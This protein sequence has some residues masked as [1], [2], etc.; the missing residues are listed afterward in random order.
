MMEYEEQ[1]MKIASEKR[2]HG[3]T[4]SDEHMKK[5]FARKERESDMHDGPL[6][7][8]RRIRMGR[9]NYPSACSLDS[10]E[11]K[12]YQVIYSIEFMFDYAVASRLSSVLQR[13]VFVSLKVFKD[14]TMS[15]KDST[16][17]PR[18]QP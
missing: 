14:V 15:A 17:T 1:P 5:L 13:I 2:L 11:K 9:K 4:C 10:C 6:V 12:E 8:R 18:T 3:T 16:M 7:G